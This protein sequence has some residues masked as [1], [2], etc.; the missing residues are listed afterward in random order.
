VKSA[1]K[2]KKSKGTST[3]GL[4]GIDNQDIPGLVLQILVCIGVD[5][6]IVPLDNEDVYLGNLWHTIISSGFL[7]LD[8]HLNLR[9]TSVYSSESDEDFQMRCE[10]TVFSLHKLFAFKQMFIGRTSFYGGIKWHTILHFC[11]F[12]KLY[13][14]E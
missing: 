14:A 9:K 10:A 7:A 3:S 4:G 6:D 11:Y 12:R 13:G 8:L 5:E 1:L 2:S